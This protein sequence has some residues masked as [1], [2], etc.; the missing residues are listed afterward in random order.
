LTASS[1]QTN[2][3]TGDA[4]RR[5][6]GARRDLLAL[7]VASAAIIMFVGTGASVVPGVVRAVAGFGLG[8]DRVLVNALLLNIALIIFGWRRYRDM[9]REVA[10]RR[11]AEAQA[12]QLA[13]TDPL[14]GCLNRRSMTP[15]LAS[16]FETARASGEAVAVIVIDLDNFKHINDLHGHAAGDEVLAHAAR[17]IS[18]QF[19]EGAFVSRLG[20]DEFA[21]AL[22][23]D[24]RR[25][26]ALDALAERVIV[27]VAQPTSVNGGKVIA[28]ASL[29]LAHSGLGHGSDDPQTLLKMADI[30]M[31]AAK[32][33]GR[34]LRVWFDEPML[35][36]LRYRREIEAGIRQGMER[37]EFVPY[38]EQQIDLNSGEL[39]GFEMLMRWH[40]PSLGAVSPEVF[41]PIAEEMGAIGEL[42]ES[43]I[44]MALADARQWDPRLTLAVNV[45]PRQLRDP[46]FAQRLL[47]LLVEVNFPPER[48]EVE[49]TESSLH[50]NIGTVRAVI[51]SLKNQGIR[52]TLD[53]FGTGYNSLAQLRHLAFD[54][55]KIDRSFV[56]NLGRCKDSA[57]IFEGIAMLGRGLGL[58]ITAEGI[59]NDSVLERLRDFGDFKGQGYLYGKPQPAAAVKARLAELGLLGNAVPTPQDAP[60]ALPRAANG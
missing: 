48:L 2:R 55:I 17:R 36:E 46:W 6:D 52:I 39:T 3:Q 24:P 10:E 4:N 1:A 35:E 34:N 42:S 20:G 58:P 54:R 29:G 51:D 26:E 7:T 53:D 23:F 37:G 8:P 44:A 60:L 21:C 9:L 27:A 38:Y 57:M 32:K 43:V 15:A 14:T 49:I 56:S 30:A 16:L 40:S 41:I 12:R 13:E 50:E 47:K 11:K 59:E 28:T 45:S 19:P 18:A 33:R 5:G 22:A 31:Y 25:P